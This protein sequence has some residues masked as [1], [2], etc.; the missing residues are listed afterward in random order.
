MENMK[1]RATPSK[2]FGLK[3]DIDINIYKSIIKTLVCSKLDTCIFVLMR[4]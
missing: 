1:D 2:I 3:F 4:Y